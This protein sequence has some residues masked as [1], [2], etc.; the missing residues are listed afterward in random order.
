MVISGHPAEPADK[1]AGKASVGLGTASVASG[2]CLA[3]VAA[4]AHAEMARAKIVNNTTVTCNLF[5]D[6]FSS[7][8]LLR[9]VI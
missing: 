6:I 7:G 1:V 9:M 3:V 8:E 2:D 4:G 5:G